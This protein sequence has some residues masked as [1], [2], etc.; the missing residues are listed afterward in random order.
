VP[1]VTQNQVLNVTCS[2]LGLNPL[3]AN[4]ILATFSPSQTGTAAG[5]LI[6]YV[7]YNID[8]MPVA[9]TVHTSIILQLTNQVG[10][11]VQIY[12]T[13]GFV[14]LLKVKKSR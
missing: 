5:S 10:S 12:D 11:A 7:P 4:N 3:T 8:F 1:Q 6:N 2:V 13:T 9:D 14:A